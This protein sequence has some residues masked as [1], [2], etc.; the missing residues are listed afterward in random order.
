MNS[1][2]CNSTQ[3]PYTSV[4]N[5]MEDG[6]THENLISKSGDDSITIQPY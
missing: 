3:W 1:K 2:R 6:W 4:Q 5:D